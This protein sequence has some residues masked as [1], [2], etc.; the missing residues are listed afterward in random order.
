MLVKIA[1]LAVSAS[2]CVI[3][4]SVASFISDIVFADDFSELLHAT[5]PQ[6]GCLSAAELSIIQHLF[7]CVPLSFV[8]FIP[9]CRCCCC[10]CEKRRTQCERRGCET[11]D[12][13]RCGC[14]RAQSVKW[15]MTS[16][17][18]LQTSSSLCGGP[19]C[20]NCT[21]VQCSRPVTHYKA[22]FF[23]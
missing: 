22:L 3:A 10:S 1:A 5:L 19:T 2:A 20:Q 12:G 7:S 17:P 14:A 18:L 15:T 16:S 23:H 13:L 8:Y 6:P 4:V 11:R 21:A 9:H